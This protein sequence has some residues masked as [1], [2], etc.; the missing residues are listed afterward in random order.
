MDFD[1]KLLQ[2]TNILQLNLK[3]LGQVYANGSQDPTLIIDSV[4][5]T[6]ENR[7][8][9]SAAMPVKTTLNPQDTTTLTVTFTPQSEGLKIADLLI[10]YNN[11]LSPHRV[12]LYGIAKAPGT[13]VT[14]HYRIN[15]GSSTSITIN[16]KTWSADTLYSFDNLE[17]Y[18][19]SGVTQINGTD[20]DA[21]Y[22]REQS[23]NGDKKPFRYEIPVPNGDYV[24]RLHFAELV[25]G[26]PGNGING[27]AGSRVMSIS[28]ENEL[29]LI[30]LDVAREVGAA[31]ALIKNIPVTV[32]D[33]KLN[34]DFSAT[35]NRP[36]VM[37]VEVYSFTYSTLGVTFLDLK[38]RLINKKVELEWLTSNEV[39]TK[40][41]EVQRSTT[42]FT[43][44]DFKI[45]GQVASNNIASQVSKYNFVDKEPVTAN[46]Y[47]RI[48]EVD[49]DGKFTYSK[50]IRID[51]SDLFAMQLFPNPATNKIQIQ[52]T[53]IAGNQ[54]ANLSI[55]TLSG[56]KIRSIPVVL[57]GE[58]IEI[59]VSSLSAGIYVIN[60]WSNEF[61]IH[62]KFFKK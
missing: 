56:S 34:I 22:L 48:K 40:Y 31:T 26:A 30:N 33:G 5:I 45:I 39:N 6:G 25:W 29:Q 16:G 19:N 14:A 20:E 2:T 32:T 55:Q 18:S 46:T 24:V 38:G 59:N 53:G 21:L 27:G 60:L 61:V 62:K 15:S 47:Y 58:K 8:E 7:S 57:S 43:N 42:S 4:Q 3:S 37:A 44:N 52:V 50:I 10:H 35:V 28:L 51:F 36:M 1:E 17:P 41:F 54:K 9:F 12:P 49:L 11:S 13:T 23:S